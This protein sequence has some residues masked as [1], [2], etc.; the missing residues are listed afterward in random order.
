[1]KTFRYALVNRPAGIGCV[2]RGLEFT[3][4]PR[5][6]E[7]QPHHY[8]ARHGILC[9]K[10]EL[11]PAELCNFELARVI[12]PDMLD[13]VAHMVVNK[14]RKYDAQYVKMSVDRPKQFV[15]HVLANARDSAPDVVY[16]VFSICDKQALVDLV[17]KYL[18]KV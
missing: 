18:R 15:S 17:V 6:A 16:S 7:G 2:P 12:E 3:V 14:L 13:A 9:T 4:E 11:T 8:Y 10:T 1:M 5:P